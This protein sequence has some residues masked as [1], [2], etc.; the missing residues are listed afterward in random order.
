MFKIRKI[1][2]LSLKKLADGGGSGMEG[3]LAFDGSSRRVERIISYVGGE[4]WVRPLP[5][6]HE[7]ARPSS[8]MD[9]LGVARTGLPLGGGGE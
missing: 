2:D 9:S 7:K 3:G 1:A 5:T 8:V 6:C 4:R